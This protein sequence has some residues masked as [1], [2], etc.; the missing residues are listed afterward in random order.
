MSPKRILLCFHSA[1]LSITERVRSVE[2]VWSW[3]GSTSSEICISNEAADAKPVL[4]SGGYETHAR[5]LSNR[6]TEEC[7]CW[8]ISVSETTGVE[9]CPFKY[10]EM[11]S[12][13]IPRV[14]RR[15]INMSHFL[16]SYVNKSRNNS[17]RAFCCPPT[18]FVFFWGGDKRS[19]VW[20]WNGGDICDLPLIPVTDLPAGWKWLR[21]SPVKQQKALRVNTYE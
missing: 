13:A 9:I 12:Q 21:L 19:L 10:A 1:R 16:Q 11:W 15:Y 6:E 18:F 5:I 8:S 2:P 14:F 7:V 17:F 20:Q 4:E 3:T